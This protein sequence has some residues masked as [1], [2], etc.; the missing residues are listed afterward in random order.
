MSEGSRELLISTAKTD[1]GVLVSVRGSRSGVDTR[2][3]RTAVRVLL[4][5]Q[6]WRLGMGLSI[7]RSIVEAH[8]G[9]LW[10]TACKPHMEPCFNLRS[11]P[12][13]PQCCDQPM[14]LIGLLGPYAMSAPMPL[15]GDKRTYRPFQ[16]VSD[17]T[18]GH[19]ALPE[20]LPATT[21]AA[22]YYPRPLPR[23][24]HLVESSHSGHSA[25]DRH[26]VRAATRTG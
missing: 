15:L 7:C 14:S 13:K 12:S 21:L 10:A 23:M 11:P 3:R 16:D 9:R 6:T 17:R 18:V 20:Q 22:P 5:H 4:H 25:P 2:E 8:G 24:V 19:L 26:P 1:P